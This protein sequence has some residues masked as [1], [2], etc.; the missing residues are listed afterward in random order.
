[1]QPTPQQIKKLE[2]LAKVLDN[3]DIELLTQLDQLEQRIEGELE[4]V[5]AVVNE[6]VTIAAETQK[7][8]GEKGE[9]GEKGDPGSPGIDGKDGR[10]G[11][12]GKNG[13]DGAV[14]PQGAPG[15]DG[16]DGKDGFIDETTIAYLENEI[17]TTKKE[18][19]KKVDDALGILDQRTQFLINKRS[20][21]SV[22]A[23]TNV[24]VDNTDP[25]NPI[26]SATV[27]GGA[28][29]WG[30]ITGTL[31][32]QTDLNSAL[33]GKSD[34]GHTHTGVYE[35][36]DATILKDAD[37]GVTVAAQGHTHT[38]VYAPALGSDDNY[39]TDAEK[40]ALHSHSN[41]TAL[42]AVTGVNT[43][44]QDLSS[45][46]T[47][48]TA[49][50]TYEPKKGTDDNFVTDAEKAALHTHSNKTV[51]DNT[52][53]S[54][55]TAQ[56]TK[57]GYVSVTQAVNLDTMESDIATNN[58]KV[59]NATHT[60]DATGST[61]LTV[62]KLQGK[63]FPTLSAA[64]DA[65]YPKYVSAS[66]AFVMTTIAGGGNVSN[67]GTP[68]NNQVAVWTDAT[69]VEGD[70]ALTFDTTTDKLSAGG[71]T[72]SIDTGTIELGHAS[73]TTL[74]RSAAGV[75]AV[76]GVPIIKA[77]SGVG[78]TP[79]ATGT[80][81]ITHGLGRTPAIIRISSKSGFISNAA[82]TPTTSSEGCW[83]GSGNRCIYQGI[84]GTT[85]IN[86]A[87]STTFAIYM[88]TSAGNLISGVIQNVGATTF[89][90]AFTETGTHTLGVYMWQAQ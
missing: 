19:S 76:E 69:T 9:K 80:V 32:D 83:D 2:R 89:D 88:I 71:T 52:T 84:N 48:A 59:S 37:I 63:D 43:G 50:S 67:T 4:E 21:R 28:A 86:A 15:R 56:E 35:P 23:G 13:L 53:A 62:V 46:L 78:N 22:T 6:A 60:G 8:Q 26:I 34:T 11:K 44:D 42:D 68:A 40:A 57:L 82:A 87:S 79:T 33:S 74:S 39:V 90:I 10:D 41:K 14:G 55:T 61:A 25:S 85:T 31:S 27:E 70:T 73:D 7:M 54:F 38:G 12:D 24:T 45:Y 65:K 5:K 29:V 30:G 20:V 58:A 51:L 75:L 16:V 64:D 47:S 66:N 18:T 36:A 77:T 72:G 49:A 17:K 81:T 1:M 3:G